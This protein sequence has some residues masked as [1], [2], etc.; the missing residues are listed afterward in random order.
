MIRF[1][2]E[3]LELSPAVVRA[4]L[5]FAS[6][7]PKRRHLCGIG[8]S[9]GDV[10]AADGHAAVRFQR[11]DVEPGAQPP[12]RWDG[13]TFPRGLVEEALKAAKAGLVR[14]SWGHAG[15]GGFPRLSQVEPAAGLRPSGPT[16]WDPALLGRLELVSKACRRER[17]PGEDVTMAIDLPAVVLVSLGEEHAPCR[18]EIGG[19]WWPTAQHEA[20]VTIMPMRAGVGDAQT[21]KRAAEAAEAQRV[22]RERKQERQRARARAKEAREAEKERKQEERKRQVAPA[23]RFDRFEGMTRKLPKGLHYAYDWTDA[24]GEL[25]ELR[26]LTGEALATYCRESVANHDAHTG[27]NSAWRGSLGESDLESLHDWLQGQAP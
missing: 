27:P 17:V 23:Q 20:S 15:G 11:V 26:G 25:A 18:Y 16:A 12:T 4:L 21:V 6:N 8:F 10:C 19:A 24:A 14:L 5:G 3:E 13:C 7:D 9:D 2:I 1:G 22:E